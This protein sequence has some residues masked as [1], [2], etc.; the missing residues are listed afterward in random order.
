MDKIESIEIGPVRIPLERLYRGSFYRMRAR[1]TLITRIRTSDGIVG[2][3]YNADS[4]EEQ[5]EVLAIIRDELAPVLIGRDARNIEGA[6]EAM[7]FS[8]YDQLCDRR[9]PVRAIACSDTAL[10]DA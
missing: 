5:A 1:C 2:E 8:T 7:L 9:L 6:W 10:W 4:D 3:A